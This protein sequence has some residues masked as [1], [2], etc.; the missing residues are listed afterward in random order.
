MCMSNAMN[1]DVTSFFGAWPSRRLP[2]P[3]R[4]R[5]QHPS[6]STSEDA[7]AHQRNDVRTHT[8]ARE[9]GT[10]NSG[11]LLLLLLADLSLCVLHKK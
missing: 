6:M 5:Q 9:A 8:R 11:T 10:P 1:M 7:D 4:L 3:Q 2:P